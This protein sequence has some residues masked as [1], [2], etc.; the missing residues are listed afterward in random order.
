VPHGRRATGPGAGPHPPLNDSRSGAVGPGAAWPRAT[1]GLSPPELLGATRSAPGAPGV[2][3]CRATLPPRTRPDPGARGALPTACPGLRRVARA[4]RCPKG[5]RSP[6]PGI[7]TGKR[8]EGR[9]G[10]FQ[11]FSDPCTPELPQACAQPVRR[12]RGCTEIPR[13]SPEVPAPSPAPARK[14]AVVHRPSTVRPPSVHRGS[15]ACP[16]SVHRGSLACPPSVHRRSTVC[17]PSVHRRSLACPP[18][19]HRVHRSR[20]Q[21]PHPSRRSLHR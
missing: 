20:D 4:R 14:R 8:P 10:A 5:P 13:L 16:P 9:T 2:G 6:T 3:P 18:G 17:P 21:V 19:L 7:A 12:S 11:A 1:G 15:L